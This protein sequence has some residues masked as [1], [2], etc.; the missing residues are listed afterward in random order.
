VFPVDQEH[1]LIHGIGGATV[2]IFA[3]ALLRRDRGDVFAKFRIENIPAGSDMAIEG[4]RLV[5]NEDCDLAEPGVQ[6]IA[7]GKIDDAILPAEGNSRLR[8]LVRQRKKSLALT[9]S[10]YHGE[11]ILHR[12]NSSRTPIK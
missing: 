2:P 10:Q 11:D 4:M 1:I 7:Q 3:D 6:T 12:V 9:A 8:T 5:L